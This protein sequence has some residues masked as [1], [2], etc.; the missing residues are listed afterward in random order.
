MDLLQNTSATT[1]VISTALLAATVA[2]AMGVFSSKNH[3]PVEG[4]VSYL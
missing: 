2:Y 1:L 3:M 4:R